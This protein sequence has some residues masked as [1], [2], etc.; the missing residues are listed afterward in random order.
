MREDEDG[1]MTKSILCM[2]IVNGQKT[3]I[4]V[5]QLMNKV[6]SAKRLQVSKNYLLKFHTFKQLT[7]IY[8]VHYLIICCSEERCRF[9]DCVQA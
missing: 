4:G 2:P 7:V 1:F 9:S 8:N 3:V 6:F 5:A